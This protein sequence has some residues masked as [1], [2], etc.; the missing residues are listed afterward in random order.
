MD[1]VWAV[2]RYGYIWTATIHLK[3]PENFEHDDINSISKILILQIKIRDPRTR[4]GARVL[5]ILNIFTV[6]VRA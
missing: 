3:S 4:R 1:R 2:Q 5:T 6:K